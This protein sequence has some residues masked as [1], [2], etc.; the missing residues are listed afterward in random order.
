MIHKY[1]NWKYIQCDWCGGLIG[2]KSYNEEYYKIMVTEGSGYI[3]N[4]CDFCKK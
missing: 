1:R 2:K 4:E 3:K